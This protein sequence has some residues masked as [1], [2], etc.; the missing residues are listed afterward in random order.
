M[1]CAVYCLLH[2]PEQLDSLVDRLQDAGVR[3]GDISVVLREPP[4]PGMPPLP[5]LW[6]LLWPLALYEW[7]G[8]AR[9]EVGGRVIS[10]AHYRALRDGS[11][12]VQL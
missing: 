11:P 2:R 8:G 6:P 7:A 3:T 5:V 9:S 4:P 12:S 10:L 1:A